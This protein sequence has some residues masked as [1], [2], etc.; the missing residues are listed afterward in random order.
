MQFDTNKLVNGTTILYKLPESQLPRNPTKLW[1]GKVIYN[2]SEGCS[3]VVVN[4][5]EPG[6]DGLVETVFIDQ[7]V[8]TETNQK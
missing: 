8:R 7:I 3:F 6:Y 1:K 2:H 4:S 5:L